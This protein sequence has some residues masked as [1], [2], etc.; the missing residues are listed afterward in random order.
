MEAEYTVDDFY[1]E[2]ERTEARQ[3]R[4]AA[5]RQ[6]ADEDFAPTFVV[7]RPD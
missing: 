7:S 6:D 4:A 3:E 2:C 5:R 1:L